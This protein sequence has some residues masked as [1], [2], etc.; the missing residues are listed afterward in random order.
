M[1][2]GILAAITS[3]T[4]F[5]SI[6]KISRTESALAIAVWFHCSSLLLGASSLAVSTPR[7]T[8]RALCHITTTAP[9]A[10]G[11]LPSPKCAAN[12]A[13]ATLAA[14]PEQLQTLAQRQRAS[15]RV[16]SPLWLGTGAGSECGGLWSQ[17]FRTCVVPCQI[18]HCAE[19]SS[20]RMPWRPWLDPGHISCCHLGAK[21]QRQRDWSKKGARDGAVP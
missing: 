10:E 7:T 20:A 15:Q 13:H 17:R 19:D 18:K 11:G 12:T 21:P 6:R 9:T 1:T 5:V 8:P 14:R 4:A 2:C 16:A 3:S